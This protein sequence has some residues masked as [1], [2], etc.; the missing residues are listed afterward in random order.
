VSPGCS[1]AFDDI[2]RAA[3]SIRSTIVSLEEAARQADVYPGTR[4]DLLRRY[5]LDNPAWAR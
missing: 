5:R 3:D 4:R 2:R 1:G